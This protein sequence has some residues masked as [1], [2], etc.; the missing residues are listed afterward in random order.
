MINVV[1]LCFAFVLGAVLLTAAAAFAQDEQQTIPEDMTRTATGSLS[2]Y[3]DYYLSDL[4]E[5]EHGDGYI[6]PTFERL[7]QLYWALAML[8]LNDDTAID[9]Y[10]MI[11]ECDLYKQFYARDFE[12]TELRKVTRESIVFNISSFPTK[13][14]VFLPVGLDRYDVGRKAFSVYEA[15]QFVSAKRLEV[16]RNALTRVV[17]GKQEI[18]KYPR[19][20]I[21]AFNRPFT[22]TEVAMPP[23]IAQEVIDFSEEDRKK[24]IRGINFELQRFSPLRRIV[25]LRLKVSITQYKEMGRNYSDEIVPVFFATIDGYQIFIDR[26]RKTMIYD[27]E[28]ETRRKLERL[29]DGQDRPPV[30]VPDGPLLDTTKLI[31][32]EYAQ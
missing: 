14:E 31:F 1:R 8:D 18:E 29:T 7:S 19:N 12:L 4:T 30:V 3:S 32:D 20:F 28:M 2:A 10:L 21:L 27:H 22:L 9:G 25:Y 16:S 23:D 13:F 24:G 26:E 6:K 15:S 5:D 17:C 11:H